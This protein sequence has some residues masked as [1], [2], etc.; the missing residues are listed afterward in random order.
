MPPPAI[1]IILQGWDTF[2]QDIKNQIL[3]ILMKKHED[4]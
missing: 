4:P 1:L 2:T 3:M